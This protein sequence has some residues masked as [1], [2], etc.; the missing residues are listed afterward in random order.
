MP[1]RRYSGFKSSLALKT[2]SLLVVF[3]VMAGCLMTKSHHQEK[4]PSAQTPNADAFLVSPTTQ[5]FLGELVF[6]PFLVGRD[7]KRAPL[8]TSAWEATRAP[9]GLKHGSSFRP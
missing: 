8:K 3:F 9:E 4:L 1:N 7:E 6:H 2:P 5:A